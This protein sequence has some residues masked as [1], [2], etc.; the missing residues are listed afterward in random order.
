MNLRRGKLGWREL[1]QCLRALSALP[2]DLGSI[3]NSQTPHVGSQPSVIPVPED[4]MTSVDIACMW[5][6]D[7]HVPAKHSYT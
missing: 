1:T 5:Y 4:L 7:T 3:P 6:T 2:E